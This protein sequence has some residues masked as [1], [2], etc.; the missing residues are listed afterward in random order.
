[1]ETIYEIGMLDTL[2]DIPIEI[3]K[4]EKKNIKLKNTIGIIIGTSTLLLIGFLIY[5]YKN[6]EDDKNK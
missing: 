2:R 6:K 3:E 5:H 4:I 1:M